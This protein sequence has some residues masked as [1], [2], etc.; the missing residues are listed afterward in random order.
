MHVNREQL[1]RAFNSSLRFVFS[2][3]QRS[4]VVEREIASAKTALAKLV[5]S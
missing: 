5:A 2:T 4:S 1:R 3:L